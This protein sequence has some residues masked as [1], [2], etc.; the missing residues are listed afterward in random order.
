MSRR[1]A[2]FG[3]RGSYRTEASIVRAA[4]SLGHEVL[5]VDVARWR[6]LGPLGPTLL[7]WRLD[8]FGADTVLLT[9][10]AAEMGADP[11]RRLCRGRWAAVW[12][13][14]LP[15]TPEILLL[16]RA[17]QRVFTTYYDG[18]AEYHAAGI[19]E[20]HWL[21]QG[22]DPLIDAPVDD[23]PDA[24]DCDA[25]FIGSGP[26]PHRWPVLKEVA[27]V[28]QLQVRGPGWERAPQ[29]IPV[30]GGEIRGEAF[31]AATC[32]ARISLG[33]SFSPEQAQARYSA[34]N[35]M[36]KVLGCGGFYLGEYVEGIE[37]FAKEGEEC[38]WYRGPEEAAAKVRHWLDHPEERRRIAAKGR[39]HALAGHTYAHRVRRLLEGGGLEL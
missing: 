38:S 18:V 19:A 11:L 8:A 1:I 28:C 27:K 6:A 39:V 10:Y 9:R 32:A 33:A 30:A 2:V 21:P 24:Y 29:E 12:Y 26:F 13:F 14:D 35:R 5:F 36:W 20:A 22:M 16:G 17:T 15:L 3:K 7:R 34:S 4:R 25:S 31:A 37:M 23:W